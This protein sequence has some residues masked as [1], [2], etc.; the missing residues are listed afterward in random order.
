MNELKVTGKQQ[1]MGLDIPV[2]LGGFGEGKKCISDKTIAEIHRQPEREI[3]RRISDNIKR[4]KEGTDYIDFAQRVGESHTLELLLSLGY[5]KQSITQAEHIYIL[6]ERGYAKLIKIMDTD[7]AWEIHDKLIDEYFELRE[8]KQNTEEE[9]SPLLKLLIKTEL[10]QKRQA[11]ELTEVK[12][13]S[14]EAVD[15]VESIR[16]VVALDTTSWRDDTRNLINKI[17]QELGGGTA[18]QQVRSESYELLEKRMGVSLKQRLTNK[19][20][21]MADEGVCKSK[22]DKLSQVDIIADDKK[23][24]EGYVAI[25]KE[26][27]IKYGIGGGKENAE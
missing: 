14:Q 21:R 7:L 1:F 24:I 5:A 3:R 15:R 19:R 16:E 6:S 4:F 17:V 13:Q 11:K 22:R 8:E 23:L 2:T 26:M 9:L 27:A 10:E 25:V 12:K 20:R 18:F